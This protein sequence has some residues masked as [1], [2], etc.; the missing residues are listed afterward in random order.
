MNATPKPGHPVFDVE[1]EIVKAGNVSSPID[2]KP[3]QARIDKAIGKTVEGRSKVRIIWGQSREAQ[4]VS[5]G[6]FRMKKA[7]W[8]F[9]EGGELHDIGVP[10]Y[11]VEQLHDRAE[12]NRSGAWEKA[13]YQWIEG[14][15]KVDVLGDIPEDGYYTELF[16]VAL[17]D[18][19]CCNGQEYIFR[20]QEACIGGYREPNEEDLERI[21]RMLWMRDHASQQELNPSAER[22]AQINEDDRTKRNAKWSGQISDIVDDFVNVHGWR[23]ATHSPKALAWGRYNFGATKSGLTTCQLA[24]TRKELKENVS[25][26]TVAE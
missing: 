8:R 18:A 12:L 24:N 25:T 13:R 23:F 5:F 1:S 26:G 4:Q 21:R 16:T 9:E 22:I 2:L 14:R 11:I 20:L 15:G 10:R 19:A 17:H 7:F 6:R 3:F